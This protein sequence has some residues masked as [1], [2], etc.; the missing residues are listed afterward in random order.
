MA[1]PAEVESVRDMIGEPIPEDGVE[2]D[3]MFTDAKIESWIDD[4]ASLE[5]AAVRGWSVKLAQWAGL[6]D[7][8]DGAASRALSDLMDH[9]RAM[10]RLYQDLALGPTAGR[11]RIGKIVRTS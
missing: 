11:T 8:T 9:G 6:V 10:L 3:T 1:T 5:A 2:T 4:A 7:V